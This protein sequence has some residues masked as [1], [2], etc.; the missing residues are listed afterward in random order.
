MA[1]GLPIAPTSGATAAGIALASILS[2]AAA[3][4]F[5]PASGG[6]TILRNRR[7]A[8]PASSR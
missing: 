5:R 3:G 1:D 4:Q 2:A 7:H 6:M 8:T